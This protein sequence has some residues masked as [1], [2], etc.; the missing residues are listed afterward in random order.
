MS[1]G[2]AR[3]LAVPGR[4]WRLAAI[5]V[6]GLLW[7]GALL[8]FVSFRHD[9]WW[10]LANV[11]QHLPGHWSWALSPTLFEGGHEVVWFFRPLFKLDFYALFKIW[12]FAYW[13]WTATMIACFLGGAWFAAAAVRE[14]TGRPFSEQRFLVLVLGCAHL[15]FFSLFWMGTAAEHAPQQLLLAFSV[16]TI[17]R[18]PAA[19]DRAR[20]GIWLAAGLAAFVLALGFKE[21][22]IVHPAFVGVLLLCEPPMRPVAAGR[23]LAWL[24]P[25]V[26]VAV[27][28]LAVRLLAMPIRPEYLPVWDMA[29]LRALVILGG[30]L[31]VPW[32]VLAAG[33]TAPPAVAAR[34]GRL[35]RAGWPYWVCLGVMIAPHL[36]HPFFSPGWL[37]VPGLYSV[38]A[39]VLSEARVGSGPSASWRPLVPLVV[40]LSVAPVAVVVWQSR[41]WQ[42]YRPQ[43]QIQAIVAA[44]PD[45]KVDGVVIE[46]C[47]NRARPMTALERVVGLPVHVESLW[48]VF[49]RQPVSVRFVPCGSLP[50][51]DTSSV[52]ELRL[53]Y[54]FPVFTELPE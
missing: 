9:D 7:S 18:L 17:T 46:N 6:G 49:H 39:A 24:S 23:R 25:Y 10:M 41:W 32:L 52:R 11:V 36:G 16:W 51:A 15:H 8:P 43:E 5:A 33:G 14:V 53:R 3:S 4:R 13:G 48:S 44:V 12:G 29:A 50:P 28:Y 45:G 40:L 22:A 35:V 31:A 2:S 20:R 27:S 42:W 54:E 47:S 30:G 38:L 19:A 26:L 34:L 37:S 1:D 21:S